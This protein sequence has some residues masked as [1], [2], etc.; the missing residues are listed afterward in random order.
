[1]AITY[2]TDRTVFAAIDAQLA[3]GCWPKNR[4]NSQSAV[5]FDEALQIE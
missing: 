2:F 4:A 5:L 3:R 1:M